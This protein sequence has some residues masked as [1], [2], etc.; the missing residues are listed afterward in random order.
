[1]SREDEELVR[2]LGADDQTGH[3]VAEAAL[4]AADRR[5][6]SFLEPSEAASDDG[7]AA[8]TSD[9]ARITS[10]GAR[11]A[12][13]S[14]LV[15]ATL[16]LWVARNFPSED[17]EREKLTGQLVWLAAHTRCDAIGGID[18]ALD[19][20]APSFW[21]SVA[22]V[23]RKPELLGLDRADG[24]FAAGAL[25][26]SES[27][28][29]KD[30]RRLLEH[31]DD[32]VIRSLVRTSDQSTDHLSGEV[33]PA[34]RGVVVTTLLALT[35]IV[36]VLH[37]LR[38]IGRIAF[39]YRTPATLRLTERGLELAHRTELLGRVLR[40]RETIVP[41]QNL[42]RVT[43]E[44]RFARA[45]LYA[46]LLA[47][48]LGSYLGVGLFVDG[49]RVPGGSG[50]LLGMGALII[51]MGLVVDFGLTAL[52]D[53]VRGRCRIVVEPR[54]GRALAVG[55]LDPAQADRMLTSIAKATQHQRG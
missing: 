44:V 17:A 46:G 25:R 20:D 33:T 22:E 50:S 41:L 19:D 48:V 18:A 31:A 10:E 21:Q 13:E 38:F 36:L 43:R 52:S 26:A 4:S 11:T 24:V 16:A 28:A 3:L 9:V 42:A 12:A 1:M 37:V 8:G 55:T 2:E 40:D 30:A 54:R 7:Q 53:S 45:G 15:G 34:P 51:V 29:A 35:G 27:S 47:L 39:R 32:A 49:L 5:D 14:R 6:A 23:A